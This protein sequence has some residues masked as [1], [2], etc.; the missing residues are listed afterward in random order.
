MKNIKKLI[1]AFFALAFMASCAVQMPYLVTDN[2]GEKKG[3]AE[4][5]VFLGFIRPM[6][7]DISIAKAAKKGGITKVATV[8]FVVTSGFFKTTYK[9]V[10]TG[11]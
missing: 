7:A 2:A 10:V 4:F 5:T 6:D 11:E 8:D 9:T 1:P 3:E